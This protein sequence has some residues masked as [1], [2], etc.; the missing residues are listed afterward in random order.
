M[1]EMHHKDDIMILLRSVILTAPFFATGLIALAQ[2]NPLGYITEPPRPIPL[3][4]KN[5]RMQVPS[6]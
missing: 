5:P 1:I 2:S 6:H 3:D 4:L